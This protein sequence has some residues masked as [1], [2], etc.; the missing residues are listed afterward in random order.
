MTR[1]WNY[2]RTRLQSLRVA[3]DKF[4]FRNGPRHRP[5]ATLQTDRPKPPYFLNSRNAA[6]SR[7]GQPQDSAIDRA[8]K[9]SLAL[10]DEWR[11]LL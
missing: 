5:E 9:G 10:D 8:G 2:L 11:M 6:F 1:Y 3:A 4:F 7:E